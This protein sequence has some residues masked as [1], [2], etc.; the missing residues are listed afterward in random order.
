MENISTE[1]DINDDEVQPGPSTQPDT[2]IEELTY[3]DSIAYVRDTMKDFKITLQFVSASIKAILDSGNVL[4][5]NEH[6]FIQSVV[7]EMRDKS[8]IL[9]RSVCRNVA[10]QIILK[11]PKSFEIGSSDIDVSAIVL[12][13]SMMNH[14]NYINR[15][16]KMMKPD[17]ARRPG[18][19]KRINSLE[20]GIPNFFCHPLNTYSENENE[21]RRL[22]LKQNC[23]ISNL[24][25]A[26]SGKMQKY[27]SDSFNAQRTFLNQFDNPPTVKQISEEWPHLI[28][29]S[30]LKQHF[31]KMMSTPTNNFDIERF[32]SNYETAIKN[33]NLI[34]QNSKKIKIQLD[35][36]RNEAWHGVKLMT[37]YFNENFN[38]ILQI[39]DVSSSI[40]FFYSNNSCN[41]YSSAHQL[42]LNNLMKCIL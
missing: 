26:D 14:N 38:H 34:S 23:N 24:N 39:K 7:T 42:L 1:E 16:D 20:D 18:N 6:E 2:F 27:F 36:S 25:A 5:K 13:T 37:S 22:W 31:N 41:F 10:K 40:L 3:D 17:S 30:Y 11:Y 15:R 35:D 28:R 19:I 33:L 29:N 8:K 4:G 21:E 12:T 9:P 32:D